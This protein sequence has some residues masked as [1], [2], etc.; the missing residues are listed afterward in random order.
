MTA[1]ESPQ[2]Q[3]HDRIEQARQ[4]FT[5]HRAADAEAVCREILA[6]APEHPQALNLLG[7]M[8]LITGRLDE[9]QDF[10]RRAIAA[11]PA[12]AEAYNNLGE[13]LRRAGRGEEAVPMLLHA[14]SL[15]RD[16]PQ[17]ARN[18]AKIF[19]GLDYAALIRLGES[20]LSDQHPDAAA[21]CLRI[22]AERKPDDVAARFNYGAALE[23][24]G[25]P[26]EAAQQYDRAQQLHPRDSTRLLSATR[27][28]LI[29]ESREDVL[30]SRER[31]R[32]N[33]DAL[34]REQ[35]R[36][37][38]TRI[39]AANLFQ[40]AYQGLNDRDLLRDYA[41]LIA[42]PPPTTIAPRP[43]PRDERIRIGFVSMFLKSHTIG[44]INKGLIAQLDREKFHVTVFQ[45]GQY[46]DA[47]ANFIREHADDYIE[48][49]RT[50]PEAR[51]IIAA[52]GVDLLL[53]TDIG[54]DNI[55][56][57]LAH[58]RLA[59]VQAVTWG[60]PSTTGIPT[61]D[62][63]LSSALLESPS[64]DEHY[65]EE[66]IRLANLSVYYYRPTLPTPVPARAAFGFGDDVHVYGCLQSLF[67]LLPDFDPVL[68]DILRRDPKGIVLLPRAASRH[69]EQLLA[70]RLRRT[71][72]QTMQRIKFFDPLP[73][74]QYLA[75]SATCDVLLAPI[76]FG[77]GNTSYEAFA[78]GT[79]TV[80][81]PSEFLKGRIT[82][83]LYRAMDMTDCVAASPQEYADLALQLGL[84]RDL[85]GSVRAKILGLNHILY[86]NPAG[87]RDL[88]EF[89]IRATAGRT[90]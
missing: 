35:F 75:L 74:A 31:L 70:R 68:D 83:G 18:L 20:L 47:D 38:V 25:R 32:E 77:A 73:Y 36:L 42:P 62:Y 6:V 46:D 28:P 67:K 29:Y 1:G 22:A 39:P 52:R 69:V 21:E 23:A 7:V 64:A 88:E 10:L 57:T 71:M 79:P 65:T 8:A 45:L 51:A 3:L 80:T 15:R 43:D 76:H 60:H 84:D 81:M 14:L 55:T 89:F 58:S 17:A 5:A 59:A 34:R 56:W 61:I 53:Y 63:Y 37:D 48:V 4:L 85:N 66:L 24:Q 40:L 16:Y 86:E 26:A 33:L 12:G 72:P 2:Q 9:A 27:L 11:N 82:H 19:D 13:A 44:R 87:V 49:P 30:A 78:F 50:L 54:M 90:A 41:S